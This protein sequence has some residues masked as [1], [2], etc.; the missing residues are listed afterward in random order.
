MADVYA[1]FG[2]LLALGI[3]FPGFLTA[4]WLIAPQKVALAGRRLAAGPKRSVGMGVFAAIIFAI[5]IGILFALPMA[6]SSFLGAGLIVLVLTFAGLGVAGLAAHMASHL[7]SRSESITELASF[8]RAALALELAAAFPFIGWFIVIPVCLL[9]GLG[10]ASFAF[11]GWEAKQPE[12][13]P[14]KIEASPA[15]V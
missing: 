9:A 12:E 1:V 3:A 14:N 6:F 13:G 15:K 8:L 2:T 11:L 4:W 7:V 10:A 5:P